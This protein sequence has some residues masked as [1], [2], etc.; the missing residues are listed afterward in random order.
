MTPSSNSAICVPD[1]CL[2]TQLFTHLPPYDGFL[3]TGELLGL[4][5]G[6]IA[7]LSNLHPLDQHHYNDYGF[8]SEVPQQY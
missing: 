6:W 8:V 2:P 1:F 5:E 3:V 4:L 7:L